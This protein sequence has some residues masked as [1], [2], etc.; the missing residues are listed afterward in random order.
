M[1]TENLHVKVATYG[2]FHANSATVDVVLDHELATLSVAYTTGLSSATLANILADKKPIDPI[3]ARHI[4]DTILDLLA[5]RQCLTDDQST[6]IFEAH[7]VWSFDG[8]KS[9]WTSQSREIIPDLP[10]QK[11]SLVQL[12]GDGHFNI[13]HALYR[14]AMAIVDEHRSRV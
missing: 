2:C 12:N 8:T 13:A 11:Q 6:T 9:E 14:A 5:T 1:S 10:E 4:I 3:L 7:V